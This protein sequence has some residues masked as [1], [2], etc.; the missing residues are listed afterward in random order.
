MYIILVLEF[1]PKVVV[2]DDSFCRPLI[3]TYIIWL[4]YGKCTRYT[5][6]DVLI[7][8]NKMSLLWGNCVR[9]CT[10]ILFENVTKRSSGG[11]PGTRLT[12]ILFRNLRKIREWNS[13]RARNRVDRNL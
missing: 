9:P 5:L 8:G 12:I 13:V 11:S 6:F 3:S 10:P 4:T 2:V 1:F 7:R